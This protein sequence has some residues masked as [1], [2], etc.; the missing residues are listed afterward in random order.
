MGTYF[1]VDET[2]RQAAIQR[3]KRKERVANTIIFTFCTLFLLA[4]L[5]AGVWIFIVSWVA[6]LILVGIAG[7]VGLLAWASNNSS[8]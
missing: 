4:M 1:E 7:V 5:G 3:K 6:G 8:I 2:R